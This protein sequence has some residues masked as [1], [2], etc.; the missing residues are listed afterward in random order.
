M[1]NCGCNKV[2]IFP[3]RI[4]QTLAERNTIPCNERIDGMIVTVVQ[5]SN[6]PDKDDKLPK[7]YTQYML[8]GNNI[9]N[10]NN[11]VKVIDTM[12][13]QDQIGHATEFELIDDELTDE[14]LN[15]RYPNALEGF[16]VTIKPLNTTFNKLSDGTWTMSNS[17]KNSIY[18]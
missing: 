4:V 15:N 8:K 12:Q 10:N 9:C 14:Y 6:V 18:E 16:R 2:P 17:I 11:W 1:N 7:P 5:G 13:L 3:Y